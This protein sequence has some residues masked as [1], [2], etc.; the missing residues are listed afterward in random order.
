M[1]G[2][3][4]ALSP[5][6]PEAE[7]LH[8][9][10]WLLSLGGAVIFLLTMLLLVLALTGRA[11]WLASPRV[12]VMLGAVLPTIVLIALFAHSTGIVSALGRVVGAPLVIEVVA[13]Q[14]WWEVRY[15]EQG[16][17]TANEIRLPVGR[18]AEL[19]VTSPDVIHALWIPALHGKIDMIPGRENRLRLTAGEAGTWRGQCAEF[20]GS[21]HTLMALF[22]VAQPPAE[23]EAW[24]ARQRA[25]PVP[26]SA[27]R[28]VFA[29]AGCGACHTVRGTEFS[30]RIG[31]DLTL[32]GT[33]QS[34]GAGTLE[35]HRDTL[36]QW[37]SS[38]QR[39]KPGN[40]M[41]DFRGVL[42]DDELREVAEWLENLR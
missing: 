16:I 38:P 15:P 14:F 9:L 23:F 36:L 35:N 6:G 18:Q 26:E 22:A 3:Q 25:A 27:G 40:A 17:V 34:L 28:A 31:P 12:M 37:V 20:C 8:G 32:I 5:R 7:L 42:S 29:R 10:T 11:R 2:E 30:G 24:A 13:R 1:R 21:Q 19:R 33:R 4:S 39:V 41:P